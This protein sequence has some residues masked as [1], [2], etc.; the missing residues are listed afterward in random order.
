MKTIASLE[1]KLSALRAELALCNT[2]DHAERK[3][4][5]QL[6][7]KANVFTPGPHI[8]K[9]EGHYFRSPAV[10]GLDGKQL[11]ASVYGATREELD[12]NARV[13]V[14]APELLEALEKIILYSRVKGGRMEFTAS[15]D[16]HTELRALVSKARGL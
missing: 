4:E 15:E 13:F 16:L 10:F 12:A 11:M 9:S 7:M 2:V 8:I 14:A 6:D 3:A 5:R 1:K